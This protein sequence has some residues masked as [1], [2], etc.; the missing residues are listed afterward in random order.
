MKT[1]LAVILATILGAAIGAG[2]AAL[3]I[4]LAP[5]DGD[6]GGVRPGRQSGARPGRAMPK[7]AVDR[8]EF[9]FGTMDVD[10]E[11]SH[12]FIF[13]NAGEGTLVV[14][15]G[16]TS[17]GCTVSEIADGT[18]EPGESGKVTVKWTADK[19]EGPYRQTATIE[20]ND[21]ERPRVTLTVS[22][23]IT[24]QVRVEPSELVFGSVLAGQVV[25][26]QVR[27][28]CYLDQP[29]E[30]LSCELADQ[31]T[32]KSF[33]VTF[34]PLTA[35]QLEGE[36]GGEENNLGK[37]EN[38]GRKG[39]LGETT[40]PR[41]GYLLKVTVKPGLPLGAFRQRIVVRTNLESAPPIEIPIAGTVVGDISIVGRGWDG[42]TGVLTLGVVNSQEGI[43][44]RLLLVVR[45][46]YSKEVRFKLVQTDPDLLHV[47]QEKLK[48]TKPIGDGTVTQTPLVIQVPKGSR[49]ANHLGSKQ[50]P[51]GE[52]LIQ[53][54]HPRTPQLRVRVRFAVEG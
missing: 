54:N 4:A 45:G 51:L 38:A 36:A 6:P 42:E 27:L 20:T 15:A 8:E 18:I 23:L 53:A 19:G 44:R 46:P 52:I 22:G 14:T 12:D 2:I 28:L 39:G 32:A 31:E 48:E 37:E 47:D 7:V 26:E 43:Q 24:V 25:A 17:C 50:G 34:Q 3:G 41:S 1:L 11:G 29:L 5:W 35:D 9:Q 13:S 21:P 10:A 49:R 40:R 30:I 16:E 33:E